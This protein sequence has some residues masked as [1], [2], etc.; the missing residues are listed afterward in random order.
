M[1]AQ[2]AS[3]CILMLISLYYAWR[4]SKAEIDPD[5]SMFNFAAFTGAVYGR[6][7]LDCKSPAIHLWYWLIAKVVGANVKRVR[8]VHHVLVCVPGFII[9]TQNFWAGLAFVVLINSGWL[10]AFHGNVGQV[11]AGLFALALWFHEPWLSTILIFSAIAFEPKLAPSS[12]LAAGIAGWWLPLVGGLLVCA[13][14]A[15]VLQVGF[16]K[17]WWTWL[18]E[19]NLTIPRRMTQLRI[20][21]HPAFVPWFQAHGYVYLLPWVGVAILAKPDIWYWLPAALFLILTHVGVIVRPN[22][23]IPVVAW[24]VC[25]GVR[26]ELVIILALADLLSSGFYLD[27]LWGRFYIGLR[28]LNV[29]AREIGNWLKDKPGTLWVNNFHSGVYIY[30]RKPPIYGLN[31]QAEIREVATERRMAWRDQM[32][33]G[34]PEF[35]VNS[36]AG[37]WKFQPTGYQLVAQSVSMK[38]YQKV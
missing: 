7:F 20:T 30:S 6:D 21:Q 19:A 16:Y 37:G 23:L 36:D 33:H 5:W 9:G 22:H 29:E 4:Y 27:D 25:A 13:I 12:L 32:K 31:E 10:M 24:V 26:P 1:I 3:I 2:I 38:V 14:I 28:Q 17:T 15:L 35:A 34:M 11:P 8:F 18:V